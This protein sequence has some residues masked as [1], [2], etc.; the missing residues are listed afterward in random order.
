M[1]KKI[2]L[3]LAEGISEE[4]ALKPAL[5]KIEK[6]LDIRFRF[7][8]GDVLSDEKNENIPSKKLIGD[9]ASKY[10]KR[11]YL[12]PSNILL[13]AQ[14]TDIDGVFIS[15]DKVIIDSDIKSSDG[16]EYALNCIKTRNESKRTEMINR[17]NRKKKHLNTLSTTHIIM[18]RPYKIFYFSRELEH[19]LH[20]TI[21]MPDGEKT[22]K[23][24]EFSTEYDSYE[25]FK[26]FF[27]HDDVVVA[28]NYEQTWNYIKDVNH[29]LERNSN[30]HLLLEWI[31][32]EVKKLITN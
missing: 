23:A 20:N 2:V 27:N 25:E 14:L 16:K 5:K 21:S 6:R 22:K 24:H 26:V 32:E 13:I 12:N 9:I 19:V 17:N 15:E 11:Y 30:F 18:Q 1:S 4:D 10:K 29:S 7:E 28:G 3:I 31:E 8:G